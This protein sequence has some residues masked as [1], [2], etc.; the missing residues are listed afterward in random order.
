[1]KSPAMT[2]ENNNPPACFGVLD[3]V[4]P[5]SADGL[6]SSPEEC[7]ACGAKT[8]C[9]RAALQGQEGIRLKQEQV[10]RAFHAGLTGFWKRWSEK[11]HLSRA[12]Q[13]QKERGIKRR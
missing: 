6:R 10:D 11:K 2:G 5:L 7:L 1:M 9:L 12:S 13:E 8:D 4:F 3:R